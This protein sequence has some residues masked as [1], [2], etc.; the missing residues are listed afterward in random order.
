ML[1]V[2]GL[3]ISLP[4][5]GEYIVTILREVE[6]SIQMMLSLRMAL[7]RRRFTKHAVWPWSQSTEDGPIS[8]PPM[9]FFSTVT[10]TN[11]KN[12]FTVDCYYKTFLTDE[13]WTDQSFF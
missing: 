8:I 1:H 10:C 7:L 13:L 3:Q 4:G 12:I 11:Y 2:V 6:D 9:Y 5:A